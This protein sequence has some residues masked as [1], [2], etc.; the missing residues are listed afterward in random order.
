MWGGGRALRILS[1]DSLIQTEIMSPA[2][3]DGRP[4]ENRLST[5]GNHHTMA[6]EFRKA[7]R[8]AVPLVISLSGVSG[9]GK[10]Y[11]ALL[12]AAGLAG[13]AGK[14]GMIDTEN[15]RGEMYADSPGIVKALPGGYDYIR[16]DPPF[17]P[18][19]YVEYIKAAE[20]AGVNV[21]V[22]D[23]GSHEWEGIGGVAEMAEKL[24]GR[25]GRLGKWADPKMKHKRFMYACLTSPM[26]IIF[27]LRARDKVKM[28][29]RGDRIILDS[30]QETSD[31]QIADKDLVVPLGLQPIAEKGMV[32]EMTMSLI[33]DEKTHFAA[34]IK[35]PEPLVSTF[36]TKHLIT[37]EDGERIAQWNATG[38]PGNPF[39]RIR[40]RARQ[41]AE[42][43]LERYQDFYKSLTPPQ[44]K[45]IID[46]GE[47][48]RN[49][50]VAIE[51]DQKEPRQAA[52]E[53]AG[54]PGVIPTVDQLPDAVEQVLGTRLRAGG[55][56]YEVYDDGDMYRW[57]EV[58]S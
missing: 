13:P 33:L 39:E 18:D 51:A 32:F 26:H 47:H 23:S 45:A 2:T 31:A 49:K 1:T 36:P 25:M 58:Q 53:P 27:C 54:A 11:S 48:E 35:V 12:L 44:K 14:V 30:G 4:A 16:F 55:R 38:A 17:S 6:L 7:S 34:P 24:E 28:F 3:S 46:D 10:T 8:K 15:G 29:K 56:L 5:R 41:A 50:Q 9:C 40:Q 22:I 19:R 42:D 20:A 37:K 21:C 52:P 57:R 43:G